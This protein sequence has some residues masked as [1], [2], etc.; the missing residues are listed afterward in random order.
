[1][2][3][4]MPQWDVVNWQEEFESKRCIEAARR[5]FYSHPSVAVRCRS[6]RLKTK[7]KERAVSTNSNLPSISNNNSIEGIKLSTHSNLKAFSAPSILRSQKSNPNLLTRH[8]F[9]E[10]RAASPV[11]RNMTSMLTARQIFPIIN[12]KSGSN[13]FPPKDT[14]SMNQQRDVASLNNSNNIKGWGQRCQTSR[15]SLHHPP[16]EI[17]LSIRSIEPVLKNVTLNDMQQSEVEI[18]RRLLIRH[19][20]HNCGDRTN[21][22]PQNNNP[23]QI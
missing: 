14:I 22:S 19:R 8:S 5:L 12:N 16:E 6:L 11:D 17:E 9:I 7:A 21:R 15:P 18:K 1:M 3:S 4:R 20:H 2:S 13:T 10:H 23:S